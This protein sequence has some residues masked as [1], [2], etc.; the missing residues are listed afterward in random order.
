MVI[1]SINSNLA[2]KGADMK[3]KLYKLAIWYIE[4]CNAEWNKR[5]FA[6][7]LK[8]L[9][10]LTYWNFG[11]YM[12]VYGADAEWRIFSRYEVL[13]NAIQKLAKYENEEQEIRAKA[14]DECYMKAKTMMEE[15]VCQ[16]QGRRNGKT[17]R[18]YCI[19]AL[20]FLRQIAEEMRGA[21]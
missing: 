3:S 19:Q 17:H 13:D 16:N 20:E 5:K 14:I 9:D 18:M 11:K 2:M 4:K 12:L 7:D 1:G 8:S 15:L 6:D 21:K 10:R